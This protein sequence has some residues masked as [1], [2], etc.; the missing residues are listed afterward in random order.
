MKKTLCVVMALL[1]VSMNMFVVANA[2][3]EEVP[4]GL[5]A[6]KYAASPQLQVDVPADSSPGITPKW[7]NG[8]CTF[9]DP[10]GVRVYANVPYTASVTPYA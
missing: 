1:V 10:D 8:V 3:A 4:S 2:Q 9:I 6:R 7:E 5:I